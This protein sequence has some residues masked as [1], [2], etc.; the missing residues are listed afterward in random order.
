MN[1]TQ[2][3]LTIAL[4]LSALYHPVNARQVALSPDN[5]KPISIGVLAPQDVDEIKELMIGH[6][7]EFKVSLNCSI[8]TMQYG[9]ESKYEK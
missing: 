4:V 1:G 8:K 7:T 3:F 5:G 2:I 6:E 9:K